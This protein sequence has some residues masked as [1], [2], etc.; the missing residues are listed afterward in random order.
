MR[1]MRG[2]VALPRWRGQKVGGVGPSR[3]RRAR[4]SARA[5]GL[6]TAP[7]GPRAKEGRGEFPP[8]PSL[9]SL[10]RAQCVGGLFRVHAAAAPL[11][12]RPRESHR[13]RND[14]KDQVVLAGGDAG[15]AFERAPE[16]GGGREGHNTTRH[17]RPG[18][19]DRAHHSGGR[20]LAASRVPCEGLPQ[21]KKCPGCSR[22]VSRSGGPSAAG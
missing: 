8:S 16:E 4:S 3:S 2:A 12:S 20:G 18:E 15:A 11:P 1:E 21:E 22:R 7:P 6:A 19:R 14:A 5:A 9:P 17:S 13:H 10:Q